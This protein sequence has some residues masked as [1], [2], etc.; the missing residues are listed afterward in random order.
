M[1]AL[2]QHASPET[3]AKLRA[4]WTPQRRQAASARNRRGRWQATVGQATQAKNQEWRL[5]STKRARNEEEYQA[6]LTYQR[7]HPERNHHKEEPK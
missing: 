1:P 3:K 2:N 7:E 6:A 4:A 5:K